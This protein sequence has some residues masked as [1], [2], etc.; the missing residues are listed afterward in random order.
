MYMEG[1]CYVTPSYYGVILLRNS[2]SQYRVECY[3][4]KPFQM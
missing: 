3:V 2:A 4:T 1:V